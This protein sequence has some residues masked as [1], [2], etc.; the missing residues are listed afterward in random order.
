M[1][2][3]FFFCSI[4]HRFWTQLISWYEA[5]TDTEV[6]IN[7]ENVSLANHEIDLINIL[8]I[9]AK[10]HIF[11]RKLAEREPN[12]YIF[13]ERVLL[14]TRIERDHALNSKKYK[15]FIR[16]WKALFPSTD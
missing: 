9:L 15:P 6:L 3:L 4:T 12:I 1:E 11:A 2:H 14:I 8:I 13:R 5:L 10:Q 16:K 7:V